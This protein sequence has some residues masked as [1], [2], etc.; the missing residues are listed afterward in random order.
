MKVGWWVSLILEKLSDLVHGRVEDAGDCFLNNMKKKKKK[1]ERGRMGKVVVSS[2]RRQ[3]VVLKP[4]KL[5]RF[6][7]GQLMP[8]G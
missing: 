4:P 3:L 7:F 6:L 5:S 8:K 2:W 1:R